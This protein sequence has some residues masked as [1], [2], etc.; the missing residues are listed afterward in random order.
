MYDGF[1]GRASEESGEGEMTVW[2]AKAAD[3]W[4]RN[5]CEESTLAETEED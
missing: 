3:D 5:I 4:V 2:R 1:I